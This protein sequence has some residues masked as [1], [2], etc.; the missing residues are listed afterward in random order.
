[1]AWSRDDVRVF[2]MRHFVAHINVKVLFRK[3]IK[4]Y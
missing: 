2:L 4:I 1:M 3:E